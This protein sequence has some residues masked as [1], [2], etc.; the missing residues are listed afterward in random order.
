MI[1]FVTLSSTLILYFLF[2]LVP[3]TRSGLPPTY[4]E[5]LTHLK[6]THHGSESPK[7]FSETPK[8]HVSHIRHQ[9]EALKMQFS[10]YGA[11]DGQNNY[12]QQ[13]Y[14]GHFCIIIK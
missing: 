2:I 11:G 4:V 6:D 1:T 14:K 3:Q 8:N 9:E 7:Q 12:F 10:P 13:D 5:S